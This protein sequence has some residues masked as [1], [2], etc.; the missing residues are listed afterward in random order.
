MLHKIDFE[1]F[2]VVGFRWEG[3]FDEEGAKQS[4]VQFFKELQTKSRFNVYMEVESLTEVE[5][6]GIWEEI[7]FEAKNYQ[8]M[9][10][11]IDKIALV[12]DMTWMRSIAENASFMVPKM[13]IKAFEMKDAEAAKT[14]VK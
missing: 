3:K 14:W 13:K 12:T 7:K 6:Q 4:I 10:N 11:E 8:Q 5:A 1:D 9:L 2:H